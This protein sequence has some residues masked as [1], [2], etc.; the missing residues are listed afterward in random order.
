MPCLAL[1]TWGTDDWKE[2]L[3][4]TPVLLFRSL[5][6]PLPLCAVSMQVVVLVGATAGKNEHESCHG[7][8]GQCVG[9]RQVPLSSLRSMCGGRLLAT[10]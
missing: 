9:G 3:L 1:P 2:D 10:D 4:V 7:G 5:S 8:T 6:L